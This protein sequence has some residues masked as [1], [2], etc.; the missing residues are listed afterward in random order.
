MLPPKDPTENKRYR[1]N[2]L[3]KAAERPDL[4]V[5]LLEKSS[6]D[7]LFWVNS[8]VWIYEPRSP[9]K[10]IPFVTY[11]YED[12]LITDI[13]A[14]IESGD[15]LF[16][17]KS[18]DMGV[19]WTVL[20]VF[21]WGFRF[22]DWSFLVGSRKQEEVDSI[23]DLSTLFPKIRFIWERLPFWMKLEVVDSF[24]RLANPK[25]GA[26][27][28]G[29]ATNANFGTGGRYNASLLD[30]YSKWEETAAAA[31]TSL[32]QATPCRIPVAT[33]F[34]SGTKQA[35]LRETDIDQRHYHWTRHPE[36]A[37]GLYRITE[38]ERRSRGLKGGLTRSP[39]YDTQCERMTESEI[40]QE[41]DINYE[42]SAEGRV[43]GLEWDALVGGGRLL[44]LDYQPGL[45]LFT[46]WDFGIGDNTAVIVLQVAPM[47]SGIFVVDHY[48]N[49]NLGIVHYFKWLLMRPYL[50]LDPVLQA[51]LENLSE[52][53]ILDEQTGDVVVPDEVVR[54]VERLFAGHYGDIAGRQRNLVTGRSV[55]EWLQDRGIRMQARRTTQIDE[56]HAV[57][58]ALARTYVDERLTRFQKSFN[59]F[60]FPWDEKRGEW[61]RDPYHDKHSHTPK[62]FA[63]F[64]VNHFEPE[65]HSESSVAKRIRELAE[66]QKSGNTQYVAR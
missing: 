5:L 18:R 15:D 19:T 27:I 11:E 41:L 33:P 17:D 34:G 37:K 9:D 25:S 56:Q 35:E 23:G 43:Y 22:R 10:V 53:R 42:R 61:G 60:R 13:V 8:F 65:D 16:V 45:P 29:E 54:A 51:Y 21:L 38:E 36:K 39:W 3:A 30:E 63:Y 2:L 6:R 24:M 40:A 55:F 64:A 4:R 58:L 46:A 47:G 28:T 50:R 32:A 14:H 12:E 7:P 66:K 31:W 62:A 26:A 59:N 1:L 57:K 49:N 20:A 52:E 48:E 44:R